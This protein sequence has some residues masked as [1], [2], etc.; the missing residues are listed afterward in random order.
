MSQIILLIVGL[1][2]PGSEYA[3]T[4]H[5]T[6]FEVIDALAGLLNIKVGK[7]K[8]GARV[9]SGEFADEKFI[10]LKP[11]RYMNRSGQVVAT[12]VGFYKLDLKNLMI[13]I[14]A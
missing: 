7:R 1:G 13:I 6:G 9:G 5:N 12:A 10:L 14:P 8:F 4:R 11:W 3:G 2:N